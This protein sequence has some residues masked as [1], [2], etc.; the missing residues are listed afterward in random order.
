MTFWK[1]NR[2]FVK[3][4]KNM[5]KNLNENTESNYLKY[6]IDFLTKTFDTTK[7]SLDDVQHIIHAIID[8]SDHVFETAPIEKFLEKYSDNQILN[9]LDLNSIVR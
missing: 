1:F 9:K 2:M 6:P 3:N 7:L 4:K 8:Y 5:K